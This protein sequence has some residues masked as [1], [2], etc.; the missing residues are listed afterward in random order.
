MLMEPLKLCHTTPPAS[1]AKSCKLHEDD[2][3]DDVAVELFI[4]N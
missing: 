2:S 4:Q 3:V 1:P